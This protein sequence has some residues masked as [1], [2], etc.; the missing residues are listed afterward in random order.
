[1]VETATA[2]TKQ[3]REEAEEKLLIVNI[4]VVVVETWPTT[5]DSRGAS[6]SDL[7]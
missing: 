7:T 3:R 6:R 5:E 1:M 2:K 4:V